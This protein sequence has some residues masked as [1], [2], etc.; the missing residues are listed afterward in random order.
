MTSGLLLLEGVQAWFERLATVLE[1]LHGGRD[2][3]DVLARRP[4]LLDRCLG[5]LYSP[6][7]SPLPIPDRRH[8]ALRRGL[9]DPTL[10]PVDAIREPLDAHATR[11][12]VA[13]AGRGPQPTRRM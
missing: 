13:V 8:T 9:A 11:I 12:P 5:R 7:K 6:P 4:R 1:R 3:L 10:E 2:L